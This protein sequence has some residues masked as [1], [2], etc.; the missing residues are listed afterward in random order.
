M[1]DRPRL[2]CRQP[3]CA[4]VRPCPRHPERKAR[5]PNRDQQYGRQWR[6]ARAAKLRADPWCERCLV[7]SRRTFAEE[8][9]HKQPTAEGGGN[10]RE[11]LESLCI[12]CHDLIDRSPR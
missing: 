7:A 3:G 8:V 2:P 4:G 1:A 12:P 5:R 10:E 6:R 9:H 11:N